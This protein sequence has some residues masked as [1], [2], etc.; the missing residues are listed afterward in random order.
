MEFHFNIYSISLLVAGI[1]AG[2]TTLV[3][4]VKSGPG[5]RTFAV[6][7]A[8]VTI[9]ALSY[10]MELSVRHIEKMLFWIRIEYIGIALI[11][12][13]WV[14]F[15]LEFTGIDSRLSPKIVPLLF[16]LPIV[17]LLMVW[18]NS[19]H[20]LHYS[21]V[22]LSIHGELHFLAFEAGPWYIFHVV[23]FYSY[24]LAGIGLLIRKYLLA[25]RII[26]KQIV[27][28]LVGLIVPWMANMFYLAG[29]RPFGH[30]DITP[31]A[32]V[33]TGIVV[34]IALMRFKL[35]EFLPVAREKII[36]EMNEGVLILNDQ[37]RV[38]DTNPAMQRILGIGNDEWLDASIY[39]L[40]AGRQ[41]LLRH[42]ER[43]EEAGLEQVISVEGR[44]RHFEVTIKPSF[45]RKG[46]ISGFTLLFRDVTGQKETEKR[47]IRSRELAEAANKYKSDFLAH[48][49]H[50]IRTPLNGVVGFVDLLGETDLNEEQRKYL[51]IIQNS[52]SFLLDIVNEILDLSKI[53]AG[54]LELK[55]EWVDLRS[56]CERVVDTFVWRAKENGIELKLLIGE[57]L[58]EKIYVDRVRLLQ[59]LT[60]LIGNA[61]KFTESGSV[62][63]KIGRS[64]EVEG[65][66][67]FEIQDTGIGIARENQEKIFDSFI[68]EDSS[69]TRKY[70]GTGL[71]LAI[72]SRFLTLMRSRLCLESEPGEGS[73][74]YFDLPVDPPSGRPAGRTG[75]EGGRTGEVAS[76][77][78]RSAG[79]NALQYP[80]HSDRFSI[81]I[82]EDNPV[83]MLLLSSILR[84]YFPNAELYD[85]ADGEEAIELFRSYRPDIILM[86][87]QMP[88]V[89]GYEAART[90]RSEEKGRRTPIIAITAGTVKDERKRSE[91][92]GMDD[93]LHKPVVP[94]QIEETLLR[95]LEHL[96]HSQD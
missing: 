36:E 51:S 34:S 73:V 62:T 54:K 35:F 76:E 19:W 57:T 48:M 80:V 82:V 91:E 31:F 59:V 43:K 18:T 81:L 93:F 65:A 6:M 49:S 72:S 69:T 45:R 32:F 50:E 83:N 2:V 8:L 14:L 13:F 53:E 61:I 1:I 68:Q 28:I 96:P 66:I 41:Q 27:A 60:N 38:L 78:A 15:C 90:I 47:I 12:A 89:N 30:L 39:T 87:I 26:R 5:R 63:L 22:D 33:A 71:G 79:E 64:G 44:E 17:T 55:P 20:H 75:K 10:G 16:F 23:I 92:A 7:M 24:L 37:L 88:Q 70:S 84:R 46:E 42:L 95:W 77:E 74:F 86:D 25:N 67:R 11:P 94:Q 9:W 40:L 3:T 29:N 52:S 85:A 56:L 58:P 21:S 4:F